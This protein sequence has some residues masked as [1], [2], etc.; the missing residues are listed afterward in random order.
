MQAVNKL[1]EILAR[2]D[3]QPTK[4]KK[5]NQNDIR[6]QEKQY[7]KLHLELTTVNLI[8]F[9]IIFLRFPQCYIKFC[10]LIGS[11]K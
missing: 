3:L 1:A 9:P 8:Y 5:I 6:R 10:S 2:K 4:T 7:R 11:V